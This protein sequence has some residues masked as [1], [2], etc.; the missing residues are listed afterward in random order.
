MPGSRC[1]PAI[2]LD[3]I[4]SVSDLLTTSEADPSEVRASLPQTVDDWFTKFDL[5]GDGTVRP[6]EVFQMQPPV[7]GEAADTLGG[8]LTRTWETMA[9]STGGEE[10]AALRG[11]PSTRSP[12]HPGTTSS[13]SSGR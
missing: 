5:D 3:A 7:T 11:S 4:R 10:V 2:Q 13:A 6:V 1:S 8:F 12:P 9:L